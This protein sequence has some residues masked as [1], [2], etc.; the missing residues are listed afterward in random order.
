MPTGTVLWLA[1]A[2]QPYHNK[3][4]DWS[5][6]S[7]DKWTSLILIIS[8]SANIPL[9]RPKAVGFTMYRVFFY[10]VTILKLNNFGCDRW[11]SMILVSKCSSVISILYLSPFW[12]FGPLISG[13]A[14]VAQN[15]HFTAIFRKIYT[16]TMIFRDC[17]VFSATQW[18]LPW[19]QNYCYVY[20]LSTP[21]EKM[22]HLK[23]D[24][25]FMER[26]DAFI[27]SRI[28]WAKL[29]WFTLSSGF[30]TWAMGVGITCIAWIFDMLFNC[31]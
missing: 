9:V 3:V 30:R 27:L 19:L 20:W 14:P 10:K 1:V 22:L 21:S 11:I 12:S 18:G 7:I 16:E 31:F 13:V 15:V 28:V 24:H 17:I 5:N 26:G 23:K 6:T 4:G 25:L 2:R 29:L 8:M